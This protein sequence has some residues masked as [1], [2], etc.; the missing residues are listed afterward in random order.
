M[1]V[2]ETVAAAALLLGGA[3]T[4]VAG[5]GLIRLGDVFMR[6]HASTK[7]GTLGVGLVG[8]ALALTAEEP[9]VASRAVGCV[10]FLL[11]TGPVGAH[12]IGR[13]AARVSGRTGKDDAS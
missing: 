10:A 9:G 4:L 8:L 5:V 11:M 12:L 3:F 6:M 2:V 13:A 1:S 7:A